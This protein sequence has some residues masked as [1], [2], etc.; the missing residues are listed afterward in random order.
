[1]FLYTNGIFIALKKLTIKNI[2]VKSYNLF[3][4]SH[5]KCVKPCETSPPRI[6]RLAYF[7]GSTRSIK[8]QDVKSVIVGYKKINIIYNRMGEKCRLSLQMCQALRDSRTHCSSSAFVFVL[9]RQTQMQRMNR[10]AWYK[11]K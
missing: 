3:N 4:K 9:L 1:M 10:D 6:S 8:T 11:K 2:G 7:I 5:P